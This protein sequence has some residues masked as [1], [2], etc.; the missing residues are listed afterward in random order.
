M[1]AVQ[2][3][4][5]E[6]VLEY[7]EPKSI[8]E[9]CSILTQYRGKAKVIAG[10][11][12]LVASLKRGQTRPE[13]LI[14]LMAIH[15]LDDVISSGEQG[16]KIGALV[17]LYELDK[18]PVVRGKYTIL[19]QAVHEMLSEASQRWVYYMATIGG[20]LCN[21]ASLDIVP[22]LVALDSKAKIQGPKGW[23][24]IPL[25]K[26]FTEAGQTIL[27][28]D[29]ILIE[30]EMQNPPPDAGLAYVRRRMEEAPVSVATLIKLDSGHTTVEDVRI[31]L[32]APNLIRAHKAEKVIKGESPDE[33]LLKKGAKVA[34]NEVTSGQDGVKNLVNEALLQAVDGAVGDFALGY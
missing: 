15:N 3:S 23:R 5:F 10:G 9:A 6:G 2:F 4:D 12:A 33:R 27:Q 31:F 7:I 26:F 13:I 29:E 21:A 32:A 34:S 30:I 25:E 19:S 20:T 17:T 11:T 1:C 28:T 16:L 14:N 22:A 18:S 24:T 8:A